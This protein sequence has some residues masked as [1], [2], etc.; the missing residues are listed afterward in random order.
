MLHK[1]KRE[2]LAEWNFGTIVVCSLPQYFSSTIY[3][4][5]IVVDKYTTIEI[6]WQASDY[7]RNTGI[8][9]KLQQKH[10]GRPYIAIACGRAQTTI[11]TVVCI[12]LQEG[13]LQQNISLNRSLQ[14]K[15]CS[16]PYI[17]N[18]TSQQTTIETLRQTA[19]Y[20]RNI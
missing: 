17:T 6:L 4:I 7:N 8:D 9:H 20:N 18:E 10:C 19:Y 13:I 15:H 5:C 2:K 11:E 12:R 14:Q 3:V 1:V 16:R